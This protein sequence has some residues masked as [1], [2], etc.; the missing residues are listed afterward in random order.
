MQLEGKRIFMVEDNLSNRAIEQML[1]ECEG[2][3][4]DFERWGVNAVEKLRQFSPVDCILL[5]L[6]FPNGVTG[7]DVFD[8][9]RSHDEFRHIP[10]VAVS[11]SDPSTAIPKTRAYGFNG[12]ISKPVSFETF[13]TQIAALIQA[14]PVWQS[15]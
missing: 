3:K 8:E 1:L 10:I 14:E 12:F 7:Y 4:V 11:A 15:R 2:A 6:M 9:I 5:D 13:A